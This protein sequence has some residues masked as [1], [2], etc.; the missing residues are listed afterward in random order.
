M[1][2]RTRFVAYLIY[3]F[4]ITA[5]IYPIP[6]RW[7]WATEGWLCAWG[8]APLFG[9]G[10]IDFAGSGVVHML[11]G[12]AGLVGSKIV[13][14]RSGRFERSVDQS[15]FQGH[16]IALTTLGVYVSKPTP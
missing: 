11:G 15:A 12:V 1:A 7:V 2:E 10:M 16:S 4:F 14:P 6:I 5:I 8:E 3:A 9:L 13:G